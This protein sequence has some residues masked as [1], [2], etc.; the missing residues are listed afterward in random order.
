MV[1]SVHMLGRLWPQSSFARH[2]HGTRPTGRRSGPSRSQL[3]TV[4]PTL[5]L[6]SW[7]AASVDSDIVIEGRLEPKCSPAAGQGARAGRQPLSSTG[8]TSRSDGGS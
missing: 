5:T 7:L 1:A 8:S 3:W 6:L 4:P 2:G